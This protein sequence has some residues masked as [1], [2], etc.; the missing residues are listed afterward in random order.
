[1]NLSK[2]Y[3]ILFP[4]KI[5]E[6]RRK[7]HKNKH[8]RKIK[9]YIENGSEGDLDI[10]NSPL[11]YLPYGLVIN[12]DLIIDNSEIKKL[13]EDIIIN[14]DLGM[15]NTQ[16]EYLP[17]GLSVFNLYASNSSLKTLPKNFKS[18]GIVFYKNTPMFFSEKN[19]PS[20]LKNLIYN[21]KSKNHK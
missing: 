5:G 3:K 16:I 4:S 2:S 15:T 7:K 12:G 13:P 1:M 11:E 21:K 14:G 8:L 17:E 19:N 6:E 18:K 20:F 9:R 10:C